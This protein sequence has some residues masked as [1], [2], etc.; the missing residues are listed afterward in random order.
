MCILIYHAWAWL[1]KKPK[2]NSQ[3]LVPT[4]NDSEFRSKIKSHAE[5]EVEGNERTEVSGHRLKK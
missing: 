1:S 3:M 5:Q 4:C 2:W